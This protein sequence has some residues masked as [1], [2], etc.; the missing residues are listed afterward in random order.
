[1]ELISLKGR[2]AILVDRLTA[3]DTIRRANQR[4]NIIQT[5]GL[6]QDWDMT[7]VSSM[8]PYIR[9]A[10]T[11]QEQDPK[12]LESYLFRERLQKP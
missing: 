2:K 4:L 1:M 12:L 5:Y 7:K 10:F 11:A 3:D 8:N 6:I 9:I